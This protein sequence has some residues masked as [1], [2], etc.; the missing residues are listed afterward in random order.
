[1]LKFLFLQSCEP[2][3]GF[4][5]SWIFKAEIHDPYK[6]FI[7]ENVDCFSSKS[8]VQSG[9]PVDFPHVQAD[10]SIEFPS[11]SIRVILS[12][13]DLQTVFFSYV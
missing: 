6:E 12:F 3:C 10:N 1:M 5:R 11:A 13:A 9:S 4:I 2:Y 8:R 7:V